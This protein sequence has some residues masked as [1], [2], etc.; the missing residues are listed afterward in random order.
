MQSWESHGGIH[1][2]D[3]KAFIFSIDNQKV[4]QVVESNFAIYCKSNEGP[5]FGGNALRFFQDPM[6]QK[7]GCITETNG[8][9]NGSRY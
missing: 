5:S 6:N 3:E 4:Y 8:H 9:E 2:T 7:N 1:K